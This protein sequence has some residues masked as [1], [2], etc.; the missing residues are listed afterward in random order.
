MSQVSDKFY[1]LQTPIMQEH[2]FVFKKSKNLFE[3]SDAEFNYKISFNWDGRGGLSILDGISYNVENRAIQEAC[4][5]LMKYKTPFG[6]IGNGISWIANGQYQIPIMA[7]KEAYKLFGNV[8]LKA[9]ANMPF[10][11]KYPMENIQHCVNAVNGFLDT[12]ILPFFAQNA[13]SQTIYE[14][15]FKQM[16]AV[17]TLGDGNLL[18]IITLRLYSRML[19]MPM[20]KNVLEYDNFMNQMRHTFQDWKINFDT[21]EADLANYKF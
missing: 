5:K 7:S 16:E 11:E 20:P 15:L 1:E 13:N 12:T 8:N 2:N 17:E 21:F 14:Q 9:L 10:E 6:H 3:K 4:Y 18:G 19:A